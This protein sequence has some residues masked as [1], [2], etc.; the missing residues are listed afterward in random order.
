MEGN[1]DMPD[2]GTR[3]ENIGSNPQARVGHIPSKFEENLNAVQR[4]A[5]ITIS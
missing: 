3:T 4:A 2:S 1:S 5:V